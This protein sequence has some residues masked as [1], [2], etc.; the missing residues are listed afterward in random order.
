MSNNSFTGIKHI[1]PVNFSLRVLKLTMLQ[2][3]TH[4]ALVVFQKF[5][6]CKVTATIRSTSF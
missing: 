6:H 3:K 5:Y 4:L 2:S 1:K